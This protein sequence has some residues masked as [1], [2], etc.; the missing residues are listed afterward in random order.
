MSGILENIVDL[1]TINTNIGGMLLIQATHL[2]VQYSF[3]SND[4]VSFSM[5]TSV[6]LKTK[7]I[8]LHHR[9]FEKS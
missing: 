4:K 3:I 2:E 6:Y 9:S 7:Y 1:K 5:Y 8:V